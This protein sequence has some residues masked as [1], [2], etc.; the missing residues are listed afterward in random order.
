[1]EKKENYKYVFKNFSTGI[2]GYVYMTNLAV[3]ISVK[4]EEIEDY[5]NKGYMLGYCK[6]YIN[7]KK[8]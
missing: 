2:K 7:I 4:E 3:N 8:L 6:P 5:I 1:M